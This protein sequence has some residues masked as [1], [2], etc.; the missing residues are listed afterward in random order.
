MKHIGNIMKN[1]D[2]AA[3][4]SALDFSDSVGEVENLWRHLGGIG[5][6][7]YLFELIESA[8]NHHWAGAI[9]VEAPFN[10]S[11]G[12]PVENAIACAGV[13][14]SQVYPD[15]SSPVA[16]AFIQVLAYAKGNSFSDSLFLDAD[17]IVRDDI[18]WISKSWIDVWRQVLEM[19]VAAH[20][21]ENLDDH[22]VLLD[23]PILPFMKVDEFGQKDVIER[24]LHEYITYLQSMKGQL[25]AGVVSGPKSRLVLNLIHLA[26]SNNPYGRMLRTGIRDVH[27]MRAGL[28]I[29]ERSAVFK[30]ASPRNNPLDE[31]GV[32]IYFF[33]LRSSK[34]EVLRVEIPQ[35]ISDDPGM[36]DQVQ[37]GILADCVNGYPYTL[38]KAD[39]DVRIGFDVAR[40]LKERSVS[41]FY[42]YLGAGPEPVRA[43]QQIKDSDY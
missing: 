37:A 14:G 16:W 28:G 42:S 21:S 22:L 9:P 13:D 31:A 8:C 19:K 23:M 10:L 30:H 36:I 5:A 7:E 11:T 27:L 25:V 17:D 40:S 20:T 3:K 24:Q 34:Q 35:W 15:E 18:G 1:L 38:A 29:G 4:K 2:E 32:G 39:Q 41:K 33:F 43:K 26:D 6:K 12:N